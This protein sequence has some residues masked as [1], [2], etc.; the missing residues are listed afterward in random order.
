MKKSI[1]AMVIAVVFISGTIVGTIP[2]ATAVGIGGQPDRPIIN[3]LNAIGK[4]LSKIDARLEKVL[5]HIGP[6]A[7]PLDP[8]MLVALEK[9][10]SEASCM[11]ARVDSKLGGTVPPPPC[12]NG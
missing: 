11:V 4:I 8:D 9:I 12:D 10:R 6:P 2:F 1:F 5:G 7:E 3:Q